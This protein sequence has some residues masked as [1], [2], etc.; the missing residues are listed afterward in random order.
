LPDWNCSPPDEATRVRAALTAGAADLPASLTELTNQ[1]ETPM[2]NQPADASFQP[3][4]PVA[5]VAMSDRPTFRWSAVRGADEYSVAVFDVD[6]RQ[7]ARSASLTDTSWTPP[8]PL[9]R[10]RLYMWQV[11]ARRGNESLV[12]PA[13]PM[14]P[15]RFRVMNEPAAAT[16]ERISENHPGAHLLLGILYTEAGARYEAETH[17]REVSPSDPYAA[18]A[19]RTL[20]RLRTATR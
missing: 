19:R 16:L 14:P 8:Q 5:T 4:A 10:D 11:T 12:A 15:A 20:E 9:R 3:I 1:S 2:G 13:P 17:L 6:L 7:V 18:V